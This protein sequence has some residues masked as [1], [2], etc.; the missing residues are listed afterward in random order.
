MTLMQKVGQQMR[1]AP[2]AP[3]RVGDT[4]TVQQKIREGEKERIQ[5]FS[6]V[7][8][9]RRGCGAGETFTVRKI[10]FGEGVERVFPVNS[11]NVMSVEVVRPGSVRRAKLYYLRTRVGKQARVRDRKRGA[12]AEAAP[13]D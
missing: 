6:G 13:Q 8:I 5:A 11:P 4:V 12:Q 1:K 7:V 2:L 9:G 10:S 3:F